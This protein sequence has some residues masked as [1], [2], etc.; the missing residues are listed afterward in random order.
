VQLIKAAVIADL[1]LSRASEIERFP[2]RARPGE[3][4]RLR[5]A[6]DRAAKDFIK[7]EAS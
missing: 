4:E 6:V 5:H 2:E 7:R 1:S 3:L